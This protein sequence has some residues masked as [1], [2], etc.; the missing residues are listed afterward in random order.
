M[1]MVFFV[2]FILSLPAIYSNNSG[3]GLSSNKRYVPF[4]KTT[5]ANQL[6]FEVFYDPTKTPEENTVYA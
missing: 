5:L 2:M 6:R 1:A 4:M 3:E